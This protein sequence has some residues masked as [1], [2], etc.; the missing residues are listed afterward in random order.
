MGVQGSKFV[1]NDT[2]PGQGL[3]VLVDAKALRIKAYSLDRLFHEFNKLAGDENIVDYDSFLSFLEV[4]NCPWTDI[5]FLM[6][7]MNKD[8]EFN[9]WEYMICMWNFLGT[10]E[11]NLAATMF[12]VFDTDG[13]GVLEVFEVKYLLQLVYVF[14]PP[15]F[16]RWAIDKLN[17][18]EDG[19]F[20]IAEFVL[21]CR[22]HPVLLLPIVNIRKHVR[23][24]VVHS[25]FWR[26]AAKQRFREFGS[27]SV[28]DILAI[29]NAREIKLHVLEHLTN[30]EDIPVSYKD[31]WH[32]I[33]A[34]KNNLSVL[35]ENL[36]DDL[37]PETLTDVQM[38]LRLMFPTQWT[39]G[40]KKD[41][42]AFAHLH[43]DFNDESQ[44]MDGADD[45]VNRLVDR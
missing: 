1:R 32:D 2:I 43:P 4:E 16:A 41:K 31:K 15:I 22:H 30:R 35:R 12:T 7:D 19:Y 10:S 26:E 11:D 36:T 33:Q 9:F 13:K 23:K 6:M 34:K 5:L 39:K 42:G 14:K 37:P 27:F 17:L 24:R 44:L 45:R 38:G 20:T 3:Q 28:F 29:K 40:P 18:N 21:L 8:G 25:R